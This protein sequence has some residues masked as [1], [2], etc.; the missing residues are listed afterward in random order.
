MAQRSP[1]TAASLH[2]GQ[3]VVLRLDLSDFF[4]TIR[5]GR[6]FRI[7]RRCGYP[8]SGAHVLTGLV[9]NRVPNHVRAEQRRRH[10][11]ASLSPVLR[12]SHLPQGA[13]TFPAIANLV[14]FGMDRRLV[15]LARSFEANYSRYADDLFFSGGTQLLRGSNR[16]RQSV[17][18]IVQEE[19]FR[20]NPIKTAVMT[21]ADRQR[22]LGLVVNDRTNVARSEFDQL[23]AIL[24][25][26][27]RFGP[28]SQSRE[29]EVDFRA[30]LLGRVGWVAES[31]P[32]RGATL[33]WQFDRIVW[34]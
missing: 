12:D 7:F 4:G 27:E 34:Q 30:H 17:C 18:D 8:E 9:T 33:R 28:G 2:V 20:I 13:P 21:R 22:V 26:C 10:G 23:R 5:G 31:N 32:A 14:A 11:T 29:V 15:G 25:N 6:V 1:S 16:F 24:W 3:Q 19:G